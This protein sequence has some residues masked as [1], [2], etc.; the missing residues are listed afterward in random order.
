[1]CRRPLCTRFMRAGWFEWRVPAWCMVLPCEE[2][3]S[4]GQG[5]SDCF[6][7]WAAG[8]FA[9]TNRGTSA[10]GPSFAYSLSVHSFH[11]RRDR[12]ASLPSCRLHGAAIQ[13]A[14]PLGP[15]RA[16][17]LSCGWN[18]AGRRCSRRG[19]PTR[20]RTAPSLRRCLRR[21]HGD[22]F[23]PGRLPVLAGS[24]S[25]LVRIPSPP[26]AW[27]PGVKEVR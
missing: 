11:T 15:G 27:F 7:F 8:L 21:H 23:T 5:S 6:F 16:L 14:S 22:L 19:A 20:T 3:P 2:P 26:P 12:V 13:R 17:T 4:L 25:S 1:M 18:N 24:P 10:A 9:G